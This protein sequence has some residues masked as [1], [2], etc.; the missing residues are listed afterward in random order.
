[1]DYLVIVLT[2]VGLAMDAF[3]VSVVSGATCKQLRVRHAV[4]M[5]FFFGGFQ[6]VMPLMGALA[7]LTL[8]RY[9]A[10]YDHWVA[11]VLLSAVGGKMIW[12]SFK[13]EAPG[14]SADPSNILVLLILSVATSIDALAVGVTL[15]LL[16]AKL[17]V[18]AA[19]IGAV[20]FLL[21]Y[22]GVLIGKRFGHFFESR[23]EAI[24]GLILVALGLRIL[25]G[26]L[27]S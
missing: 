1:M 11:F 14:R 19:V 12:E 23:I 24:G 4:R 22:A 5:A 9:I 8:R 27:L 6:A 13:I 15:S 20:T 26:D 3:A 2:A 18:A 21:S 7:G 25:L 17:V 16:V 10:S